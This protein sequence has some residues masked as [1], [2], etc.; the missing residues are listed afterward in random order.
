MVELL[1]PTLMQHAVCA[2]LAWL[3]RDAAR[4]RE[5]AR[6]QAEAGRQAEAQQHFYRRG[7][8]VSGSQR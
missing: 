8:T 6:N 5:H 3:E 7:P 4:E 1:E 2:A